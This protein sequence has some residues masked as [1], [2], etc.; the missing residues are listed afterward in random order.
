MFALWV[1]ILLSLFCLGLG[2]RTFIQTRKTKLFLN[3]KRAFYL[4]VSGVKI[5]KEVLA[6]DNSAVDHLGEDWAKPIEKKVSFSSPKKEGIL[7][8]EIKDE[9]SRININKIEEP[10]DGVNNKVD[11]FALA[12]ILF[13]DIGIQEPLSK[14][15]YIFDYIDDNQISKGADLE[16]EKYGNID[17]KN[18]KLSV[19][20]ELFSIKSIT[21]E[22]YEKVTDFFTVFGDDGKININTAGKELLEFLLKATPDDLKAKVMDIRFGGESKYYL[23][24]ECGEDTKGCEPLPGDLINMFRVKSDIFRIVSAARVDGVEEKI[25]C[26]FDRNGGKIL[27]WNER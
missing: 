23:D 22:D 18:A 6:A 16:S 8:I 17:V 5:A 21:K 19:L 24:G 3:K 9:L 15:E 13:P 1:F 27:Y 25:I 7:S 10:V 4:A 2:F 11:F 14:L 12:K 26:V 20:E